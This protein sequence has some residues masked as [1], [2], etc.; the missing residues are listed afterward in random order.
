MSPCF[1]KLVILASN[2]HNSIFDLLV[3]ASFSKGWSLVDFDKVNAHMACESH[4]TC[5]LTWSKFV[6]VQSFANGPKVMESKM[7]LWKLFDKNCKFVKVRRSKVIT[8]NFARLSVYLHVAKHPKLW[9]CCK[10]FRFSDL[11]FQDLTTY[12][13]HRGKTTTELKRL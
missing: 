12:N 13:V 8:S 4:A 11:Q 9:Y 2:F 7:L 6:E 10:D 1:H 5:G 3:S